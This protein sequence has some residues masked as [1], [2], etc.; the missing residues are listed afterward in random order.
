MPGRQPHLWPA[1]PSGW[2]WKQWKRGRTRWGLNR[3]DPKIPSRNVEFNV[4]LRSLQGDIKPAVRQTSL[5]LRGEHRAGG[6]MCE[7]QMDQQGLQLR[8]W[9]ERERGKS[10]GP[11]QGLQV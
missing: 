1:D 10:L 6:M 3:E 5:E 11:S 4:S 8:L 9:V 2:R 7:E